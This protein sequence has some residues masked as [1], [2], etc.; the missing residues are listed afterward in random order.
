MQQLLCQEYVL[1]TCMNCVICWYTH[2]HTHTVA[3]DTFTS[4]HWCPSL[5]NSFQHPLMLLTIH[6]LSHHHPVMSSFFSS[7]IAYPSL[8][9][10]L[11]M[12]DWDHSLG[13]SPAEWQRGSCTGSHQCLHQLDLAI[14]LI[15]NSYILTHLFWLLT[16]WLYEA[17][18]LSE[19]QENNPW[20]MM[21]SW[22]G[23]YNYE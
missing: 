4:T 10:S 5:V 20:N 13:F 7:A 11:W 2:T 12:S 6:R 21:M 23:Q 14:S 16:W 18:N 17:C 19:E 15:Y 9:L 1:F 3:F 22:N 8:V